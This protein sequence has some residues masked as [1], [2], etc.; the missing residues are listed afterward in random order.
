MLMAPNLFSRISA[1]LNG[2]APAPGFNNVHG[3]FVDPGIV[4]FSTHSGVR[5][6]M[7]STFLSPFVITCKKSSS[8]SSPIVSTPSASV[9][10]WIQNGGHFRDVFAYF[11]FTL[12]SGD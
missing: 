8:S 3:I 9:P 2:S 7:T 12:L 10:G 11:V 6:S 1:I 5:E 4:P